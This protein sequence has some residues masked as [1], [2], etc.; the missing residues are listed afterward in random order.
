VCNNLLVLKSYCPRGEELNPKENKMIKKLIVL[1]LVLP[2][3]I[4]FA[5]LE[6]IDVECQDKKLGCGY[7][8]KHPDLGSA[9]VGESRTLEFTPSETVVTPLMIF[10]AEYSQ[11]RAEFVWADKEGRLWVGKLDRRSG[12]FKQISGKSVLVD[13]EALSLTDIKKTTWGGAEWI[14]TA[15][16]DQLVY[17]KFLPGLPHTPENAR[18]ALAKPGTDGIWNVQYLDAL[19]PRLSPYGSEDFG[20]ADPRITYVDPDGNHYLRHLGTPEDE[21]LLPFIRAAPVAVRQARGDRSLVYTAEVDGLSQ[22]FRYHIDT[23]EIKQLTFDSGEKDLSTVPWMWRAPEFGGALVLMTIV[24]NKELRIYR[25]PT[26]EEYEDI[27]WVP[28]YSA[29][30]SNNGKIG[31]PEPFTYNG[32]SYVFLQATVEP[33]NFPSQIWLSNID[34]SEPIL[35]LLSNDS[36]L[37][38]RIDP[39]LF[40]SLK[41]PYLYFNRYNPGL[42]VSPFCSA[43][44]EGVY[45]VY[46][47]LPPI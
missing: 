22:V 38:A 20:D 23:K 31:S 44:S 16:G 15:D 18:L 25:S 17:T 43:C 42:G 4:A 26:D 39:E 11:A 32:R 28:V 36:L 12:L 9:A 6:S 29:I 3:N 27:P 24:N 34:S 14:K 30:L 33:N 37:R 41:G 46:T 5:G 8:L 40:I 10:D 19:L 21:E 35:R 13:A 47:G 45:R 2:A 1:M 7:E